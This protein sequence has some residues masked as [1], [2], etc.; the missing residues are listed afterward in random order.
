MESSSIRLSIVIPCFNAGEWL[1]DAV[2]TALAQTG[3]AHE[4]IVVDDGSTDSFTLKVLERLPEP[5][6]LV[7]Q[8]NK[9]LSG[10]RNAGIMAAQGDYIL[11]LDSDDRIDPE[12]G[13]LAS[14]VLDSDREVGIVYCHAQVFG[15]D[16][17]PL[18]L[19]EYSL[20]S[21]L[22][23][24]CIFA[25]AVFRR[26]D[27]LRCGGYHEGLRRG[28]EDHDFWLRLLSLGVRVERLEEVL[29]H[30]RIRH[31]SMNRGYTRSEYIEIYS[32][33]FRDNAR[34]YLDNIE[35]II[36]HRFELMD[37]VNDLRHRYARLERMRE[38][39]PA[40]LR[41]VSRVLRVR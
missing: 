1:E 5:V 27:W 29:F 19:P 10:A 11:P 20:G 2:Q 6:I 16:Q 31:D 22:I 28:R 36:A 17:G 34:L 40:S 37:Q 33:I 23:E 8:G 41:A 24:N 25:S 21:I 32:E 13:A 35:A 39:F 38:Q 14:A 26:A 30:Y 4:V 9:G 7:R 15:D 12:Y 18:I 3:I